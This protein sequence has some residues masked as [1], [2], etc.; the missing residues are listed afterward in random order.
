MTIHKKELKE[1]E[2]EFARLKRLGHTIPE[3]AEI[4]GMS[5]RQVEYRLYSK[6]RRTKKDQ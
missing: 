3:I 2:K 6:K 1:F 5:E 4:M